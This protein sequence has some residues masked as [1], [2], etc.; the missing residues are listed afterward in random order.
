[1]RKARYQLWQ[2]VLAI[3]VL[4]GLFAI[5][6]VTGAVAF[7]VVI[8]VLL[9]PILLAGPGGGL[10]AAAWV[11]SCYPLFVLAS[12]YATWITAWL[13]LGHRPRLSLDDPKSISPVVEVPYLS[14][15]LFSRGLP[16]SVLFW[17]PLALADSFLSAPLE[18]KHPSRMFAWLRLFAWVLVTLPTWAFS[19]AILRWNLLGARYVLEWYFD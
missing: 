16:L 15:F 19:F 7:I 6:G 11:A 9:T 14:T 5:F 2:I 1:M 4:A 8:G 18:R 13:V 12:L 17:M 10:R 3:A